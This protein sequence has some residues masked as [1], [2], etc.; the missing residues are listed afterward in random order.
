MSKKYETWNAIGRRKSSS[1][2]VLMSKGKG[3][4]MINK[5]EINNYFGRDTLKMMLNQPLD[6]VQVKGKYDIR[7]FL[8][9]A[10]IDIEK[11]QRLRDD[12][13]SHSES[14]KTLHQGRFK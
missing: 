5:R 11:Y 7:G 10:K 8:D 9:W 1:A 4:F 14:M 3:S 2:R 6:I 13:L 12:G